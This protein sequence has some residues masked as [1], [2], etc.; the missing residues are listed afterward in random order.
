L[1]ALENYAQQS[2]LDHSLIDLA[3]TRASQINGCAYCIHIHTS[4]ARTRGSLE[5]IRNIGDPLT[6][7]SHVKVSS[8]FRVQI[9]RLVPAWRTILDPQRPLSFRGEN[10]LSCPFSAIRRSTQTRGSARTAVCFAT[11]A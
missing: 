11:S 1:V 4:E 5:P 3:K 10:R 2:G 6:F 7:R 8:G 9:I